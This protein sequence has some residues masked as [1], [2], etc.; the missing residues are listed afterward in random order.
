[1]LRKVNFHRLA[2][3]SIGL[4]IG[5]P[6]QA[7]AASAPAGLRGK[8]VTVSWTAVRNMKRGPGRDWEDVRRSFTKRFYVSTKGQ[9]FFRTSADSSGGKSGSIERVRKGRGKGAMT[10]GGGPGRIQWSGN[11][12]TITAVRKSGGAGRISI[13][14]NGNFSGC[15]ARVIVA[16][17]VGAKVIVSKS[18][19]TGKRIEIRSARISGVSCSVQDGNAFA[20]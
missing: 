15:S 9:L 19:A 6:I 3:L 7:Y 4:T 5:L 13:S 1:M 18:I 8:T 10:Y 2:A 16:K 14:F 20:N 12:M 11:S 17:E